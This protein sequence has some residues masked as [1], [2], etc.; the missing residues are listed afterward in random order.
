M[1]PNTRMTAGMMNGMSVTN[2]TN[3]RRRGTLS[4]TQKAVGRMMA[5]ETKIVMIPI[6][7]E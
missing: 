3:G 1:I 6:V 5:S 2:S 4:R 7:N